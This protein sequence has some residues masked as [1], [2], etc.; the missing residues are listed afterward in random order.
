[1][2]GAVTYVMKARIPAGGREAFARY[3]DSVIPL[4]AEHGGALARRLRGDSGRIEVHV[5]DFP[6]RDAFERFRADQRRLAAAPL[7]EQSGASIEVF[8]LT[9]VAPTAADP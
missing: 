7:L 5:V 3:E 9:D 1:V 4:I 2:S 6:G 8:E